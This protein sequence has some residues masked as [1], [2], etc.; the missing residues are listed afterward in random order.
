MKQRRSKEEWLAIIGKFQQSGLSNAE[1][2]RQEGLCPKYFSGRRRALK[3]KV[4]SAPSRGVFVPAVFESPKP[5][6]LIELSI[7]D[8]QLKV[9]TSVE[10]SWLVSLVNGLAR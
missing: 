1:F 5:A 2:C 7:G 8:V 10:T 3:P 6:A 4:P 9:P